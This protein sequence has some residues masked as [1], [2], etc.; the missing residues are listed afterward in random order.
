MHPFEA[1]K[2]LKW[3]KNDTHLILLKKLKTDLNTHG[4]E[5]EIYDYPDENLPC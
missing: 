1:V 5:K 2:S 3:K 4:I